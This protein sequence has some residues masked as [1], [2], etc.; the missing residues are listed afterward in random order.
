MNCN[1]SACWNIWFSCG[2]ALALLRYLLNIGQGWS[3]EVVGCSSW[4]SH[5]I[6]SWC[7]NG[8]RVFTLDPSISKCFPT[9]SHKFN[10]SSIKPYE[11]MTFFREKE[12]EIKGIS[13]A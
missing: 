11:I 2:I 10:T 3:T 12:G 6:E 1:L 7:R 5:V 13:I 4:S 8:V 9:P